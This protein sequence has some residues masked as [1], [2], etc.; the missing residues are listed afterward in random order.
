MKFK[1]GDKV[2]FLNQSGGGIVTKIISPQMVSV[3]IEE[4]F[5]IPT[6]T[7]EL[8]LIAASDA[9]SRFFDK[10][11]KVEISLPKPDAKPPLEKQ[12]EVFDEIERI[13]PIKKGKTSESESIWFAFRPH[14]QKWLITGNVDI[15]LLNPTD[16]DVLYSV[17]LHQ[18]DGFWRG[19]D[20]DVLPPESG[21]ILSTSN[22]DELSEWLEGS[23][24]MLFQ[25]EKQPK[26]VMPVNAAYRLKPARFQKEDNYIENS[27]FKEKALLIN[28][29]TVLGVESS[30]EK[31]EGSDPE[32]AAQVKIA[33]QK[34][35]ALIDKFR[36]APFEAEVDL[37]ISALKDDY[38]KLSNHEILKIQTDHF[39][40]C[41]ES[42]LEA[43]YRKIIFI[44]GIGNGTLRNTILEM[45]KEYEELT[46]QNA[47]FKKYGYGAIEVV[48]GKPE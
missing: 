44:H 30:A 12:P 2:R 40:K 11:Y 46:V 26:L 34:P 41:L 32:I 18:N 38:S 8:L 29:T 36:I 19:A 17:M 39:T 3:A 5:D 48:N 31:L 4:G 43:Q 15:C 25:K 16:Y 47:S 37:H 35:K 6:L 27:F 20:Y 14:D 23:V 7:S 33:I 1:V 10:D 45:L 9:G 42:A 21:I 13:F 28:L 22:R 24:Q